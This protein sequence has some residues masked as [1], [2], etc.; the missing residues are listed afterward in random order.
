MTPLEQRKKSLAKAIFSLFYVW[1]V[2]SLSLNAVLGLGLFVTKK[3][4]PFFVLLILL[5]TMTMTKGFA[6]KKMSVCYRIPGMN[7]MVL[8]VSALIMIIIDIIGMDWEPVWIKPQP[9]NEL[10]PYV[11][12]LIVYPV[13]F[14][15]SLWYIAIGRRTVAC[16]HCQIR[17]GSH[18]ERGLIAK[19]FEQESSI[20]LKVMCAMSGILSVVDWSYY[21]LY[22]INVN[23]NSPDI[24]F[25][26]IIPTALTF[27]SIVYFYIRYTGMWRYYCFN[28]AMEAI[29]G[30]STSL[31][32][33]VIVGDYLLLDLYNDRIV[34]TPVKSFVSFTSEMTPERAGQIFREITGV[35]APMMRLAYESEETSTLANTFHY[36][37]FFDSIH[38]I[39]GGKIQGQLYSYNRVIGM[40]RSKLLAPELRSELERIYTVAM[41]WKT[42]TPEGRRIYPVK[43]YRPSFSFK[44]IKSYDVDYND[45]RWLAITVNNED[46]RFYRLRKLWNKHVNGF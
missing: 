16:V 28:P 22:Y 13:V 29:H 38:E 46:S 41:A 7:T 25:F 37:C 42:Y 2:L 15:I 27:L 35:D 40:I 20:Q 5:V 21:F 4:L 1:L 39:Q 43:H 30:T 14:L 19:L 11:S 6:L 45:K 31:R 18:T 17:H 26:A 12:T 8:L 24:F 3:W 33:I 23:Y 9:R 44:D 34:D 36:L 10:I 32:V